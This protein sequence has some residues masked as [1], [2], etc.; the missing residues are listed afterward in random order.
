MAVHASEKLA[1]FPLKLCIIMLRT[2]SDD[3]MRK[4]VLPTIDKVVYSPVLIG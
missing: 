1:P 3:D 2:P 4:N